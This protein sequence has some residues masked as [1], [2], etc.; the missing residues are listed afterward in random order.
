MC[1]TAFP[2]VL[3][4]TL[5]P[6]SLL[7]VL[8]LD[9][10]DERRVALAERL[11]V[12]L[13]VLVGGLVLGLLALG[14]LHDHDD[15]CRSLRLGGSAELSARRD[16]DEGHVVV[17]AQNGEVGDDVHGGDVASDDDNARER[18][19]ARSGRGRLS[20]GLD[21]LLDTAL[22]GVVLSSCGTN[23]S[24]LFS[25]S[26]VLWWSHTLADGLVDLLHALVISDGDSE[27][28]DGALKRKLSSLVLL[29]I[30]VVS[31]SGSGSDG[32]IILKLLLEGSSELLLLVL[33]ILLLLLG[34]GNAGLV[35]SL[36]VLLLLLIG[37]LGGHCCGSLEEAS[38]KLLLF[39]FIRSAG[40]ARK[41][42]VPID[43]YAGRWLIAKFPCFLYT[44]L[45]SKFSN[46][47]FSR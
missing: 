41:L 18:G 30:G 35:A 6:E 32:G 37:L 39:V 27:G 7:A 43:D 44:P 17:L 40:V 4:S 8:L 46:F 36:L 21:D 19:V 31:L 45:T 1:P 22:E 16:E 28:N 9:V 12:V 29:D 38:S 10:L 25:V 23:V 24:S 20:E 47:F 13:T 3:G 2:L 33:L 34:L 42:C 5:D 14:L 15:G 26:S 11:A